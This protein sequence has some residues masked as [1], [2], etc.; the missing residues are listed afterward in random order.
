MRTKRVPASARCCSSSS[1]STWCAKTSSL[2]P[3]TR[4]ARGREGRQLGDRRRRLVGHWSARCAPT[5]PAGQST[6]SIR[7]QPECTEPAGLAELHR[8][9]LLV[10]RTCIQQRAHVLRRRR[11]LGRASPPV[12][13]PSQTLRRQRRRP[14]INEAACG[15]GRA[16]VRGPGRPA[17]AAARLGGRAGEAKPAGGR[18]TGSGG[19][20]GR[21]GS[22]S[23]ASSR[24]TCSMA[25]RVS[26]RAALRGSGPARGSSRVQ[27]G[28]VAARPGRL[29]RGMP[30]SCCIAPGKPRAVCQ[31][32]SAPGAPPP[33]AAPLPDGAPPVG[34]VNLH[35]D[36]L[37]NLL[38]RNLLGRSSSTCGAGVV[39]ASLLCCTPRTDDRLTCRT[40][41]QAP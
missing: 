5:R 1:T 35:G 26:C 29:H 33:R 15:G 6:S 16:R 10:G 2:W 24:L 28:A 41:S 7:V 23:P 37:P 13:L 36:A 30:L 4:G 27:A 19:W 18:T 31:P 25:R 20:D 38:E 21:P 14:R 3:A 22:A 32:S 11:H 40:T 12:Q 8:E 34:R 17:R 39:R 9:G